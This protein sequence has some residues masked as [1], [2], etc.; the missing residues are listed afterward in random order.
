MDKYIQDMTGY[1]HYGFLPMK[2]AMIL[3]F[4]ARY[5]PGVKNNFH[6]SLSGAMSSGKSQFARYWGLALYS[7]D[8]WIS[9]ATSIS[10]PK[11][12]GTMETFYLFNKEHRYQYRGLLGE[13]D[14]II[15]DEV[16]EAP[17]VKNNLKQYILEPTYE[18]SKQ[19]SNNQ[20]YERT[21]QTVVTQNIDTK[22]LDKYA[23]QVKQVYTSDEIGPVNK[24]DDP[25]S[26]WRDDVDLTLPLHTYSN[27][28]LRYSIKR[29]RDM[30]ERLNIN[31]IDG[32]E[33]A[34]KQRFV[35][36]FY[37]GTEKNNKELT[38]TIRLNNTRNIVSNNIEI[39][40]LM[41]SSNL[42]ETFKN[43]EELIR[44]VNDF[45]YFEKVDKLL[46][47]YQKRNDAR[48]KEMSYFIIKLL[49]IIDGRDKCNEQDLKI[50]Q[51][52]LESID[53]KI[54]IADTDEFKIEGAHHVDDSDIDDNVEES[55]D[56]WG[57]E[58]S[59]DSFTE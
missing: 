31:W 58:S 50:F 41:S 19:G 27:R 6:V 48:T 40:R 21:A 37:L 15:I 16:K 32:S 55:A 18:Y 54:E 7:Q 51:Y 9:N 47:E 17:E 57:Y 30:Y 53:N 25:K 4:A 52:I 3:Q 28:Y 42:A 11:L 29:V 46:E 13:K 2:I 8:C 38:K 39:I 12:R 36:Y 43:K 59:L 56:A 14:L 5:I 1:Y 34:L 35:F 44:S 24:D 45:E 22:H 33:M 26:A 10:I 20:T 23:K 49:R